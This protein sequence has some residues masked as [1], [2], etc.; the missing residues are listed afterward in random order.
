LAT[1]DCR[2]TVRSAS[3]YDNFTFAATVGTTYTVTMNSTAFDAYLYL[4]NGAGTVLAYDDDGNGGYNAKIVYTPTVSGT[5]TIHATSYAGG[6]TGA[7]TVSLA[8]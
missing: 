1:T 7:Y 3:Y 2:S 5:L 6:A 8:R 4:L